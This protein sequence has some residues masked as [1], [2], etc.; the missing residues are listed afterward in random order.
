[1]L[2]GTLISKA[3]WQPDVRLTN[4]P[5]FSVI[6]GSRCIASSGDTVHVVWRENRD[7][8]N[9]EIYYK[10]STDG[11]ISWGPDTRISNNVFYS[12]N[13]SISV[14]GKV[15]HVVWTDMNAEYYINISYNHSTDGGTSWGTETPLTNNPANTSRD[16]SVSA[17]GSEVHVVWTDYRAVGSIPAIYYKRSTDGGISWS[18]DTQFS[19]ESV[20]SGSPSVSCS[21]SEV[22]VFWSGG[23]YQHS[24]IYHKNSGDRG[25]NWSANTVLMSDTLGS[26]YVSVSGSSFHML[27]LDARKYPYN[28]IYYKN[29]TDGGKN[30]G[31][32]TWLTN[33]FISKIQT[34]SMSVSGSNIHVVWAVFGDGNKNDIYYI[35]SADDGLTWGTETLLTN[36][37]T[38]SNGSYPCVSASGSAVHVV[39]MD[40]RDGNS[41][42]YYKRNLTNS[43]PTANAGPDQSVDEGGAVTLDGSLS[44][45][46]NSDALTY[47]WTAPAGI[48]LNSTSAQKPTFIAPNVS[49]NTDYTF[50]LIVNDGTIDSP[51]DQVI[52]TVK[53][54]NQSP[55]ANAGPDQNVNEGTT[56]TLDGSLS[57][58]PNSD[59]LTYKWTAPAGISLSSTSAQKP[60]FFAPE[61]K[62]DSVLVFSLVVNDGTIDSSPSSV[63]IT[64][65]NVIKTGLEILSENDLQI[66][67]NPSSQK[68]WIKNS[69]NSKFWDLTIL[70]VT[71]KKIY[72]YKINSSQTEIDISKLTHG[73]YFFQFENK[74]GKIVRKILKD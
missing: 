58:D 33:N 10:R 24:Q 38:K 1:M 30:W 9:Y 17:S 48:S 15:V 18:P 28:Q 19:D 21:G 5:G 54:V 43:Q 64:V 34:C 25:I 69:D 29:S 50:S 35:H 73:V 27:G 13:P 7:A 52:V 67:P 23:E 32:E 65:Q 11:G 4:D 2:L 37:T 26:P 41:E 55:A 66:Y 70:T 46:P 40:N 14:S 31:A 12:T 59:P 16:P 47:K 60:T 72:N 42:I 45:D 49:S 61:V 39:W 74:E 56:V 8:G 51:A 57:S 63:R 71:G 53:N 22:H 20:T 6:T 3:Q 68:I 36:N 44:S 62:N